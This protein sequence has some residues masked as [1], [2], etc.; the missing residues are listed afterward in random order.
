VGCTSGGFADDDGINPSRWASVA[1]AHG[2]L[3][4]R[5]KVGCIEE[6]VIKVVPEDKLEEFLKCPT[7]ERTGERLRTLADRL[8]I[9]DKDF[10][11]LKTNAGANLKQLMIEAAKGIVPAHIQDK[12]EKKQY[13]SHSQKWF[14]N[15]DE[16]A[17][18]WRRSSALGCGRH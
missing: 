8:G 2:P 12:D 18:C 4:F 13:R 17:N 1:A 11:T 15:E 5:W 6:N 3:V 10:P 7:D 14:K 16:A 9:E